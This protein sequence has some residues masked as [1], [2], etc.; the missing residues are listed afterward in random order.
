M[1][2]VDILNKVY[3]AR[4]YPIPPR[5]V[6]AAC[7]ANDEEYFQEVYRKWPEHWAKAVKI[8]EAIRDLSQFGMRDKCFVYAGC[9]PLTE[10]AAK[11]F[12][13]RPKA[14]KKCHTGHCFI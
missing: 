8:D 11:G 14:A 7:F 10:L 3:R 4:G 5:S 1:T 12:P 2:T 9:I 13:P 6:C